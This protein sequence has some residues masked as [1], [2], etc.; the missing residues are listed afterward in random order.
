MNQNEFQSCPMSSVC[1]PEQNRTNGGS[2]KSDS[3]HSSD[4]TRQAGW[5]LLRTP[6]YHI[7]ENVNFHSNHS[8]SPGC[9][10]KKA[11][12]GTDSHPATF[13]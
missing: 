3:H 5:A 10:G 13:P 11:R 12:H 7:S 6:V 9:T 8:F 2:V 4:D 1:T